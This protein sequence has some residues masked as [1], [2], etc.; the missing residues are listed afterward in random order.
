E[1]EAGVRGEGAAP[2][3][4]EWRGGEA[5]AT[6]LADAAVDLVLSAQAFHWFRAPEALAEFRRVLRPGGRLA[7]MWNSRSKDDPLTLGYREAI[8]AVGGEDPADKREFDPSVIER[9]A[10]FA[11]MRADEFPHAQTLDAAGLLGRAISASYAPKRG[12]GFEKLRA[13]LETLFERHQDASGRVT[14]RYRTK[15]YRAQRT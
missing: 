2:P 4:V 1:G 9:D 14:L 8:R 13:L 12:P 6:G 10:S 11:G 5:E 7:L 15:L 3:R